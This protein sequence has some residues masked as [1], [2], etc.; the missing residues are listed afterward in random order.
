MKAYVLTDEKIRIRW[1]IETKENIYEVIKSYKAIYRD[2]ITI[3][4]MKKVLGDNLLI[5]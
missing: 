2:S 4:N 5:K 3:E 1:D